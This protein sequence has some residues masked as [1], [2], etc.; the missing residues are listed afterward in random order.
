M[1]QEKPPGVHRAA[2]GVFVHGVMRSDMSDWPVTFSLPQG[3]TIGG[4]TSW[5]VRLTDQLL[6]AGREV[7]WVVHEPYDG[8]R[9]IDR[10]YIPKS[11]RFRCRFAASMQSERN[12]PDWIAAYREMLPTL[13]LP[14]VRDE[15][16]AVAEALSACHADALRVVA[17]N[18]SDSAYDYACLAH[19]ESTAHCFVVNTQACLQRLRERLPHRLADIHLVGH[20]IE[21]SPTCHRP[22]L[23]GRPIRVV[24]GGRFDQPVKRVHDVIALAHQLSRMNIPFEMRLVGDGPERERIAARIAEFMQAGDSATAADRTASKASVSL[25]DPLPPNEMSSLWHWTDVAV[26]MSIHEGLSVGMLEAM[27]ASCVPVVSAVESGAGDVIRHGESGCVFPIGDVVA[28]ADCIARISRDPA[29]ARRMS[30]AARD[31]IA[32]RFAPGMHTSRLIEIFDQVAAAPARWTVAQSRAT[33]AVNKDDAAETRSCRVDGTV[34]ADA[35]DRLAR[36]LDRLA[37][38]QIGPIAIYGAGRHTRALADV[39]ADSPVEIV[40]VLDDDP[41]LHERT[42]WGWPIRPPEEAD[43][44]GAAAVII[45]SWL[46]QDEIWRRRVMFEKSGINLYRIYSTAHPQVNSED[47]DPITTINY[48]DGLSVVR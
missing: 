22:P 21:V 47:P 3:F 35:R 45:S 17:W 11:P 31:A 38:E 29:L 9:E 16:H 12:R 5:A 13:L 23:D 24:Y 42:L 8:F 36:L 2:V 37:D 48:Q 4:L 15:S 1:M 44:L 14:A 41:A 27:A 6:T 46:H 26:L 32:R 18:H 43:Q 34:P 7:R 39:W 33:Q 40:G 25:C 19:Y 28:A 30:D 20:G 10:S